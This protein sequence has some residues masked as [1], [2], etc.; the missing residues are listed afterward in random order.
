MAT[1]GLGKR[2]I[3]IWRSSTLSRPMPAGDLVVADV[4]VVAADALVAAGAEGSVALAGEDHHADV[5]SSRAS[6]KACGSSNSVWGRK[7]LR[8]SGRLMVILA[9]PSAVLVADVAV[10]AG[11]LPVGGSADRG[12]GHEFRRACR[13]PCRRPRG[14]SATETASPCGPIA[15]DIRR[16]RVSGGVVAW[17]VH[18]LV[19][20]AM[21]GGP[22]FVE[23]LQRVWDQGDAVLP[24]D[25]RL[26]GP[27]SRQLLEAMAPGS[28]SSTP[29]ATSTRRAGGR[30][31]EPGD[32]LVVATSGTTGKPKGVVLTHDAVAASA[33]ATSA[34]SASTRRDRWLACLPLAHVG[35]LSVVR[36]PCTPGRRS[37][38]TDLRPAAVDDAARRGATLVS[39]VPTA[40]ARIDPGAVPRAS[41][42]GGIGRPEQLPPNA[43]TTYGMTETGS[44]F[45]YD[46]RPSTGSRCASSTAR[47]SC[48][49][50]CCCAP[51]A[52]APTRRTPTAG[53]PPATPAQS[54]RRRTARRARPP[55]AT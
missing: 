10:V 52:T 28:G 45:V 21:P 13:S 15:T 7:A 23:A 54:G 8:T 24:V 5:G 16:V 47:C 40:L 49:A 29:P 42:V 3:W 14:H 26:P 20:L 38:C 51:T 12:L 27:P 43:V 31:V 34:G 30:P 6:L 53:C 44:A 4:A 18:E 19:A 11:R 33:A 46:G 48:A 32:A 17:P 35:G 37:R 36:G 25:L 41:C 1:T 50:R 2:R 39:L 55:A 22:A 9:M